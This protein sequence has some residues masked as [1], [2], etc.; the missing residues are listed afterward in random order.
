MT[1]PD[2]Q[3]HGDAA[4]R[5]LVVVA[6]RLPLTVRRSAGGWRGE[7]SSG[8]LVAALA[9]IMERTDGGLWI[10]WPGEAPAIDPE[11]RARVLETWEREH[12]LASVDLPAG[13]SRAYYEGYSNNTLWPLL[14]G[15]PT[16][17][18]FDAGTFAAYRDAN[19]RFAAATLERTGVDDLIWVHDYQLALLPGILRD[20]RPEA[21]I[22][23]F[24]HVPFPAPEMFRI[25][26]DREA[27]LRGLLGA[28]VIGF[29]T[30]EHLGAFR[31]TLLQVLGIESRMDQVEVDGRPVTLEARPIGIDPEPWRRLVTGNA[32]VAR[33]LAEIRSRYKDRRLVLAVDR[34]DYTKGIPERLRAF[35]QFL[36]A[37]PEW[38][39]Q[40]T[41]AQV[42]VPSREGIPRYAAL[43]RTVNELV[44]DINGEL[45]TAEWT[46]V[47]YLH[48]TIAQ[49]ELAAL[50]A[51]ADVAW[52]GSLRDG[53]NLVAKEY[54]ACQDGGNGVLLLSEFAGAAGEMGEAIRI[55]PYDEAGTADALDRALTMPL[56]ERLERQAA[57]LNRVRRNSVAAWA[58]RS[59]DDIAR[60]SRHRATGGP[61]PLAPAVAE[62]R[63]A[64]ESA[65]SRA[66]FLDYD[67]T[68]V[69]LA[70]RPS[71]AVPDAG[72]VPVL[73]RLAARR[74][75]TVVI[76]S[77]RAAADLDRWFGVLDGVWLA[78]EHGALIRSPVDGGW[79]PLRPGANLDWKDRVRGSL[80][81]YLDQ[82]PGSTIEEK[83]YSLAWHYRL[84]EPEFGEWLANGVAAALDEQLAGTEV[85]VLRGNK[86]V[87]VRFAWASKGDAVAHIRSLVGPSEFEL[88]IGDDRTDED[89][90]AQLPDP[91]W[92]VKVGPGATAARHRIAGPAAVRA[93]IAALAGD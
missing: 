49:T 11:G 44:G 5:R 66:C 33:R 26:P 67:G 7:R 61:A 17:A 40:V 65:A 71:D 29:Q 63:L 68:L 62:L 39:G 69:P 8:G 4:T 60:Q 92:T 1:T 73:A 47:V 35:R 81:A 75:T 48:R 13:V 78:A 58:E 87:E 14:H 86:V 80:N 16:H 31:R 72:L 79:A 54:V 50:Y 10:G 88:A 76:V 25:L 34:L 90:F 64:F 22:G 21:R 85:S 59:I 77:G 84:V 82:A 56:D 70:S 89:V 9:P 6:N 93:L 57:L 74:R 19:E 28:D 52:V 3:R 41:L 43:R 32:V 18:V 51:A 27:I 38:R 36:V 45:G 2:D 53:M 30:Y 42:A 46:P 91:A 15:F 24:L 37:R 55:N 12:G 83:E 23:Y 20:A